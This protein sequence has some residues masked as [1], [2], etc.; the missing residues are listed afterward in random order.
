MVLLQPPRQARST[1]T[2]RGPSDGLLAADLLL[3]LGDGL[4]GVEPLGAHLGAVHDL[5]TPVCNAQHDPHLRSQTTRGICGA[6]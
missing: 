2:L 4:A 3:D 1:L 6:W 5:V